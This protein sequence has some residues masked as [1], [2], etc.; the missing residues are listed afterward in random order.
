MGIADLYDERPRQVTAVEYVQHLLRHRS[1]RVFQ[2]LRGHRLVWALVNTVL[3]Q[4]AS[5]KGFVVHRNVMRRLGGCVGGHQVMT[6]AQLRRMMESEE[7]VRSLVSQLMCVGKDVRSTTMHWSYEGSKLS[8][9][10]RY[11]SWR[12][13]WVRQSDAAEAPD[14]AARFL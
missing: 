12:P 14:P 11:L 6:R 13:P 7:T 5:G 3:L 8:A 1:G 9:G 10:V 4:E 2:G